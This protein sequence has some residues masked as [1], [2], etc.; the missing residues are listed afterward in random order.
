VLHFSLKPPSL[1]PLDH[2][3]RISAVGHAFAFRHRSWF[4]KLSSAPLVRTRRHVNHLFNLHHRPASG[5]TIPDSGGQAQKLALMFAPVVV[6]AS[7]ER[8]ALDNSY[9]QR[10]RMTV[11]CPRYS[12][13]PTA[14]I[15]PLRPPLNRV[16][17][18]EGVEHRK[19]TGALIGYRALK[20]RPV[21]DCGKF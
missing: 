9:T 10:S 16:L 20:H 17:L 11:A 13:S 1:T 21:D 2:L 4:L 12:P 6:P 14:S 19:S 18:D 15:S 5:F 8:D 3:A 7:F